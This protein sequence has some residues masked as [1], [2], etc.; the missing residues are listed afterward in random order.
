VLQMQRFSEHEPVGQVAAD[1]PTALE[2]I[3]DQLL[4]KAPAERP[5]NAALVAK[6]LQALLEPAGSVATMLGDSPL[7]TESPPA[8]GSAGES[9]PA[10]SVEKQTGRPDG[11]ADESRLPAA[12]DD[13]PEAAFV[14][15]KATAAFHRPS[16][17]QVPSGM[18]PGSAPAFAPQEPAGTP[19]EAKPEGG[20]RLRGTRFVPVRKEEL[21]AP[22]PQGS[23][24]PISLNT[25][26][27][28]LALLGMGGV[29]W[30]LLQPPSADA[31]YAR[32]AE[33]VNQQDVRGLA[34]AEDD[35]CDFLMRF[36]DD[37]RAEWLR[38]QREE[39][40]LNRLER[41]FERRAAGL[42]RSEQLAP[43]E[44]AYL[45]AI[46]YSRID[47]DRG[48]A[49]LQAILD[50]YDQPTDASTPLARCLELTRR[51][52]QKL[53][54]RIEDQA[55][56]NAAL[57]DERVR[58]ALKL[59]PSNPDRARRICRAIVELYHDKPWAADGVR[60]AEQLLSGPAAAAE[61]SSPNHRSPA[62][63]PSNTGARPS[64]KSVENPPSDERSK[65]PPLPP[66]SSRE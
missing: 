39:L 20:D 43:V 5:A 50:L 59:L 25:A 1:V 47:P 54:T 66:A 38:Q 11:A 34:D 55:V 26:L 3:I 60:A 51:R 65:R 58:A 4:A 36:P 46:Q 2:G 63:A 9:A 44:Q 41:K 14:A 31:L 23:H 17:N 8:F 45:E 56:P 61:N 19:D 32:I 33:H 35:I 53:K 29:F 22:S 10:S 13:S 52:V 30:Y 48:L 42:L 49:K 18:V 27:L 15:T 40:E 62:G 37:P 12:P 57:V 28:L 21:D 7:P 6:R 16:P 24:S 64:S